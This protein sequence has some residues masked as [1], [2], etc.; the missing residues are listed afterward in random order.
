M[1]VE[2]LHL[3]VDASG[4]E[5]VVAFGADVACLGAFVSVAALVLQRAGVE[6]LHASA[7]CIGHE[8]V[9]AV[10]EERDGAE[11]TAVAQRIGREDDV[12]VQVIVVDHG[13]RVGFLVRVTVFPDFADFRALVAGGRQQG[14][15]RAAEEGVG[16]VACVHLVIRL[17][18]FP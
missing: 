14:Q 15:R 9:V 1:P 13:D 6:Q 8:E 18:G 7:A 17:W 12:S 3:A 4:H 10:E 11:G 2:Q 16:R 5:Q